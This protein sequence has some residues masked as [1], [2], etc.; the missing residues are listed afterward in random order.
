LILKLDSELTIY[1]MSLLHSLT[2]LLQ[3]TTNVTIITE[4]WS[5][6]AHLFAGTWRSTLY[7]VASIIFHRQVWYRILSLR[8][9][10]IQC[11]GIILTP[12]ATFVP[13]F[14]LLRPP[15]LS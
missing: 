15:L 7:Y 5:A 9:A 2:T 1:H 14:V 12:K 13:N 8:Y 6:S 4:V 3:R 10:C 11:L